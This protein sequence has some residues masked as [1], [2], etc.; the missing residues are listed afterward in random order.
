[1]KTR[2]YLAWRDSARNARCP[3]CGAFIALD[4]Q[5][6]VWGVKRTRCSRCGVVVQNRLDP[7]WRGEVEVVE[8]ED[9]DT[10]LSTKGVFMGVI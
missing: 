10:S 9:I 5:P 6:E 1:M 8:R 2:V 4:S 7:T 3:N